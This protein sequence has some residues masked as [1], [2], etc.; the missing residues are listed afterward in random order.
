MFARI[1]VLT[2]IVGAFIVATVMILASRGEDALVSGFGLTEDERQRAAAGT[3]G[4]FRVDPDPEVGYT[5]KASVAREIKGTFATTDAWGMRL[6]LRKA[7]ADDAQ[8]IVVLGDSVAFGFGIKDD[9]TFGHRLEGLLADAVSPGTA[10]PFVT[11]V[12]C[13]GWN[14]RA[15]DRYLRNHFDRLRPTVVVWLP[16]S[17][18]L[19][20]GHVVS[21]AGHGLRAFDPGQGPGS[22][23]IT[24]ATHANLMVTLAHRLSRAQLAWFGMKDGRT[25]GHAVT[26]GV[27]P[28][29]NRRWAEFVA[30]AGA[31]RLWLEERGARFVTASL[32][33]GP[34]QI[35]LECRLLEADPAMPW[36]SIFNQR[37]P[38]DLLPTDAHP[39]RHAVFAASQVIAAD[40]VE[41][42]WV[43]GVNL[44]R[45]IPL[46]E[47]YRERRRT[48][49]PP[50]KRAARLAETLRLPR[51]GLESAIDLTNGT[52]FY[53]VYGGVDGD[54]MVGRACLFAVKNEGGSTL[55]LRVERP[56][57]SSAIW[58]LRIT[59]AMNGVAAGTL[60]VPRDGDD[61]ETTLSVAIPAKATDAAVIDVRL[62]A[63]S[64]VLEKADRPTG[65]FSHRLA[66][67]RFI[68]AAIE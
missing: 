18:D 13:P 61:R 22:I 45:L 33:D 8:R 10:A 59:V 66:A 6:R 64:H 19:D 5:M 41:R 28:E 65:G 15:Q 42:R 24:A 1:V 37:G 36:L 49:I 7:P 3:P 17:N 62:D 9:E 16:V 56:A 20:D 21:E 46:Q 39:N 50:T 4:P 27:T 52:G 44:E 54:G 29:S 14:F 26:T 55:T 43:R 11:T 31:L 23:M 68:R 51:D 48:A 12:A 25:W 67:F 47:A 60:E 53:Q 58:P 63:N 32:W 30:R 35:Q 2:V 38:D 40:L 57:A 34:F